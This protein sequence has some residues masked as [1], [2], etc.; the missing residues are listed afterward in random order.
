MGVVVANE[1][2]S[3]KTKQNGWGQKV[4][5]FLRRLAF[6]DLSLALSLSPDDSRAEPDLVCMWQR[7]QV[8]NRNV[9]RLPLDEVARNLVIFIVSMTHTRTHKQS[10][11]LN[12]RASPE[13]DVLR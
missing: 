3:K 10:K 9:R 11:T 6:R 2:D 1:G 12:K 8:A 4:L 13:K 7:V 5:L